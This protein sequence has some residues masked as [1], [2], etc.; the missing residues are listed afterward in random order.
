MWPII[1]ASIF[2]FV[3]LPIG[4]YHLRKYYEHRNHI[5]LI[6]RYSIITIY[7][8][9]FVC[10]RLSW[11]I[12]YVLFILY[13]STY[14]VDDFN[15]VSSLLS[16]FDE[17]LTITLSYLWCWRFFMLSYDTHFIVS[18]LNNEWKSIIN[19]KFVKSKSSKW[20]IDKM[21]TFGNAMWV[22]SHLIQPM[23][24]IN[25]LLACIPLFVISIIYKAT[26]RDE[27]FILITLYVQLIEL[28]PFILLGIIYLNTP[29]FEDSFFIRDEL[30]L[31]FVVLSIEALCNT[32]LDTYILLSDF[33]Y[34]TWLY[35]IIL[36]I[37]FN[38]YW[39]TPFA[40][41]LI[42]TFYVNNKVGDIINDC[43]FS[44]LQ[45][46]ARR[47]TD[48]FGVNNGYNHNN[49]NDNGLISTTSTMRSAQ[50]IELLPMGSLTTIDTERS[51]TVPLIRVQPKQSSLSTGIDVVKT[52][53]I[54]LKQILCH[55]KAYELFTWHLQY[56][57]SI[58]C[59]LSFVE[60][61]QYQE[62][63][64]KYILHNKLLE[65]DDNDDNDEHN[66]RNE[67]NKSQYEGKI[68]SNTNELPSNC[69]KSF[70]VY[71]DHETEQELDLE[72]Y[73]FS[74]NIE[75]LKYSIQY[76]AWLLYKKYIERQ[77]EYEINISFM[78]RSKIKRS[79]T[80]DINNE[81]VYNDNASLSDLLYL[82]NPVCDQLYSLLNSS[83]DR[84]QSTTEFEKIQNLV[85]I[86]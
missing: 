40:A 11:G 18:S 33:I 17:L 72:Q 83:Y 44:I 35:S 49:N 71:F 54:T 24:I 7:E 61:I 74:T 36:C 26:A 12:L 27:Y 1:T 66:E 13:L 43:R 34:D 58:E 55:P 68:W 21:N 48:A 28:I 42:S 81:Y 10:I 19:H 77:S 38:I 2:G 45:L 25:T 56:E 15:F 22:K 75:D 60:F 78:V 30:R 53:I 80:C 70:I 32:G 8:C 3:Y 5:V 31:L 20:Y 85:F 37:Q 63:I 50:V 84:F 65:N 41:M 76:K 64:W 79:F 67:Y 6:K 62:F 39:F 69:P 47:F 29:K 86:Q 52:N 82:F 16:T 23:I 46:N 9:I 4:V 57:F 59:M 73:Y 14:G 51:D